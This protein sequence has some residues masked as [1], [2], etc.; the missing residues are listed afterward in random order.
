[1]MVKESLIGLDIG[2]SSIK[3]AHFIRNEKGLFLTGLRL[4]E[5]SFKKADDSYN[6]LAAKSLKALLKGVSRKRSK[7]IVSFNCPNTA[8]RNIITPYMPEA[9]I[10]EA[11]ELSIKNYFPFSIEDV[12]LDFT[13]VNDTAQEGSR[14]YQLLISVAPKKTVNNL[15]FLLSKVGITPA[16]IV[17]VSFAL[18]KTSSMI[19]APLNKT[20]C[21][22]DIGL[23]YTEAVI[24]ST[25]SESGNNK[26][27]SVEFSRKIHVAGGDFTI[28]LTQGLSTAKGLI[29]LSYDDAESIKKQAGIPSSDAQDIINEKISSSQILSL[30]RPQAE[31]LR[32]EI[33]RCLDYYNQTAQSDKVSYV[34]LSGRSSA[35]KG[36]IDFISE[37]IDVP[38]SLVKPGDGFN[39]DFDRTNADL[40]VHYFSCAI[41]AGLSEAKGINLLPLEIKE[42]KKRTFIRTI[43]EVLVSVLLV[44]SLFLYIGMRV[45]LSNYRKER[46]ALSRELRAL[47][48]QIIQYSFNALL[49]NEPYWEEIFIELSNI[50]PDDIYL[51][52]FS[53]E[54]ELFTLE[55]VVIKEEAEV[56]LSDF[57]IYLDK[58]IFKDVKL[59]EIADIDPAL[60]SKFRLQCWVDRN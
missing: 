30:I 43:V 6:E 19:P 58:G 34:I 46:D 3:I 14:R 9:E 28:A 57:M 52:N 47:N 12:M 21:F 39:A 56:V 45:K 60:G 1:M 7:F 35:L 37:G 8:I 31:Q 59:I 2:T 53:K 4:E 54:N 18:S 38:V 10:K 26:N 20:V 24:V 42:A 55:G 15:L 32:D 40:P 51:T 36:L 41:G 27:I 29:K 23:T 44:S 13:I 50:I 48:P 16:S 11:I 25:K 33:I 49:S 5:I 22:V 17:P